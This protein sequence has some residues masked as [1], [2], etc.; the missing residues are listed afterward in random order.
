MAKQFNDKVIIVTGSSA[1]IGQATALLF[2][3]E[4]A[5][6]T[7]HGQDVDRLNKTEQLLR[8][9]GVPPQNIAKV[10]GS[11]E[12]ESTPAKIVDETIKKFGKIDVLI[13][14]AGA[15]GMPKVTNPEALDNLDF[16]YKVNFRS[17]IVLT[18]LAMPHLLKTKGNVVNVSSIAS[19]KT[20]TGAMFYGPLKAA[21]DMFTKNYARKYGPQGIRVNSLNPGPVRTFIVERTG[22]PG[23]QEKFDEYAVDNTALKRVGQSSEMATALKFLASNDASFI[24][25]AIL[26][27]DGGMLLQTPEIDFGQKR[28]E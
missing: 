27:A 14:N 17:V 12:D 10:I 24:T 6:L 15:G 5:L 7:I 1:G 25:G 28:T 18:Q 21:L 3:K 13:N 11:M 22:A 2:G 8:E 23:A 9:I 26:V 20:F 4:G 19:M 16:L